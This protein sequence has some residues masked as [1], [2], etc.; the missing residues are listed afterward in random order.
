MFRVDM[1]Q[2]PI[3][4]QNIQT[5]KDDLQDMPNLMLSE[6]SFPLD[7]MLNMLTQWIIQ[8]LPKLYSSILTS[9]IIRTKIT[10]SLPLHLEAIEMNEERWILI[11][12]LLIDME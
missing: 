3:L 11:S 7:P 6:P 5:L 12:N 2:Q 9:L 1:P 4:S 10:V 8:I